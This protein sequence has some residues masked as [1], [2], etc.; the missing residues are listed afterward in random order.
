MNRCAIAFLAPQVL[1]NG[2]VDVG[3]PITH[4][5]TGGVG[6]CVLAPLSLQRVRCQDFGH[7]VAAVQHGL[8]V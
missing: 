3:S 6:R 5:H 1:G 7:T 2:L 8:V 4:L